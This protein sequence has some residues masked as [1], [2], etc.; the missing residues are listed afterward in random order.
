MAAMCLETLDYAGWDGPACQEYTLTRHL[1][2]QITFILPLV[3]QA[4]K[5]KQV[6][7]E[8]YD[9]LIKTTGCIASL[10]VKSS[11]KC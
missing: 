8:S 10:S 5:G 7:W 11:S 6:A 1:L 3:F 4:C 9:P 2:I